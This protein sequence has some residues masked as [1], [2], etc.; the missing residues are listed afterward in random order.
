MV[1]EKENELKRVIAF[2][3]LSP[4]LLSSLLFRRLCLPVIKL[5]RSVYA[6]TCSLFFSSSFW[7]TTGYEQRQ[8][9]SMCD[10]LFFFF[11]N[12]VFNQEDVTE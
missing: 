11:Y 1:N 8:Q 6:L 3:F 7:I 2:C 10:F 4:A 5:P 9:V 12:H